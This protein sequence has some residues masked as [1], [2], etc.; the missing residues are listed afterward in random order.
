MSEQPYKNP[1]IIEAVIELR[2]ADAFAPADLAKISMDFGAAYPN[3]QELMNFTSVNIRVTEQNPETHVDHQ[4][5]YRFSS[6]DISEIVMLWP[7]IF[8]VSQLAP[9]PGWDDFFGR[10]ERDWKAWKSCV[11]Y[12]KI[13]RVGVRFINRIDV[14]IVDGITEESEFLNVFARLPDSFGPMTGYAVQAQLP[15]P[16][17]GCT[18]VINSAA[19]PSPLIGHASFMLDIDLAMD[20]NPPQRDDAIYELVNRIR[21]KKNQVFEACVTPRAKE[22]FNQ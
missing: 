6:N 14:P 16:D 5:G 1:P 4:R 3:R 10:F 15:V 21:V 12:K 9:Y 20:A 7:S 8:A 18:L 22:R 17:M 2:F 19:V 13:S 11:G